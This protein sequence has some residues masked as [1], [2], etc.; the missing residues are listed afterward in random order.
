MATSS[1][2]FLSLPNEL[3]TMIWKS[4]MT[5]TVFEEMN[6]Q[7]KGFLTSNHIYHF[8]RTTSDLDVTDRSGLKHVDTFIFKEGVSGQKMINFDYRR[9]EGPE[10]NSES[11][12]DE[13]MFDYAE[14]H[15]MKVAKSTNT[16]YIPSAS[17][18]RSRLAYRA[19]RIAERESKRARRYSSSSDY[20]SDSSCN[21]SKCD[22]CGEY[23]KYNPDDSV[24]ICKYEKQAKNHLK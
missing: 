12:D 7:V 21:E 8:G 18:L 6:D 23:H 13:S 16:E 4:Y 1:N 14:I 17:N 3:Q 15:R 10:E 20:D 22:F 24:Y 9:M 2:Q 19:S 11:E 5:N